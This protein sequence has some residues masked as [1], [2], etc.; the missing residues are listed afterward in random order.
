MPRGEG[1][2]PINQLF[3]KYKNRLV[4]PQGSVKKAFC[5]VVHDLYGYTIQE[6][7]LSYSVHSRTL[8][9]KIHSAMKTELLLKK[10]EVMT[11]LKGRLGEKSAPLTLL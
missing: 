3:E 9:L 2:K 4:A 7:Q 11:H 8:T 6:N 1:I 10:K 5:E